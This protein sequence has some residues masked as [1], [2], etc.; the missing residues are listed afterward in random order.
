MRDAADFELDDGVVSLV[1]GEEDGKE[2]LRERLKR[3][4]DAF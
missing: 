3:V 2:G 1:T 4:L